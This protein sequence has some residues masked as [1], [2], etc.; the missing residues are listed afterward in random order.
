M[1]KEKKST[2]IIPIILSSDKT[3]I[4]VFS[5]KSAYPVYLAIGNLPKDI[6][7]K[8]S[9]NA[10]VL[11]AYLPVASFENVTNQAAQHRMT[12]NLFHACMRKIVKPLVTAGMFFT[13]FNLLFK[14]D[15]DSQ[16]KMVST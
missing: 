3:Q 7:C 1:K 5:G 15:W 12:I 11:L 4:T 16:A 13:I 10:Q 8:P 2:T 9:M 14:I 6:R